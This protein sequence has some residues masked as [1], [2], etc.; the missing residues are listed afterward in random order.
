MRLLTKAMIA[1]LLIP[2]CITTDIQELTKE[3][4]RLRQEIKDA[5]ENMEALEESIDELN[6][7]ISDIEER[8]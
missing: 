6:R 4:G 7:K 1:L 8:F 5:N 2:G 3:T